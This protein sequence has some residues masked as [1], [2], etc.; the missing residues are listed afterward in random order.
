MKIGISNLRRKWFKTIQ[1]IILVMFMIVMVGCSNVSTPTSTSTK[2]AKGKIEENNNKDNKDNNKSKVKGKLKVHYIDVGQGDSILLQ[3]ED[4][5]MLIDAGPNAATETVVNYLKRAG[6]KKIDYLVA[7]HPH[8]DHIGGMDGVIDNFQIGTM[9]MPKKTATTATFKDVVQ[10]MKRKGIKAKTPVPG[11]KFSLG[12]VQ[13]MILAPNSAEYDNVNN[14]SIVI[15]ATYGKNSFLFE[16]DAEN[17][18]EKE[19]LDKGFD[20]RADVLKLG[21]HGSRTSSSTAYLKKVNP[22]YVVVSSGKINDY[23]HPHK[24]TM[25]K[26]KSMGIK[27]YRTDEDGN[28]VVTSDGKGI[29]FNC[30]PGSYTPGRR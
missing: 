13:C 27:L 25:D 22:K 10:A 8:E 7:T 28:I 17:L 20:V 4:K 3:Y 18:A 6:V 9:Y 23:G 21:H 11:E 15:K 14:Y 1:A 30:S 5:N 29:K 2:D 24:E 12:D 19:I 16:G 26:L